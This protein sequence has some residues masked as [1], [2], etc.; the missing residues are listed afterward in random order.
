MTINKV[1]V[2][3]KK[4]GK[5]KAPAVDSSILM[6]DLLAS[7]TYPLT[8]TEMCAQTAIPLASGHR[9]ISVLLEQQMV[10]LDPG[11]KKSYCLGSKI[12]QIASTVYNRQSIIPFFYPIAEILKNELHKS[13]FLCMPVGSKVV[14]I[15]KVESSINQAINLFIGQTLAMHSSASGQAILS[16]YSQQT[17]QSY[18][19]IEQKQD[20]NI[21]L[22]F[23]QIEQSIARSKLLGYSV[24]HD[25]ADPQVSHIAAPI[26]NLR[27]EPV[28]AI[29]IAMTSEG[30]SPQLSRSYSKNLIQAARQLSSRII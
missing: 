1:T 17:Q 20:P 28:A 9:I 24:A 4:P 13:V 15:S 5:S 16:M 29:G 8:L 19:Q 11:R 30:L 3:Q 6:L 23:A 27:N 7:T 14:V 21:T 10:A 26:L 25:Q 2:S 18:M 22:Q 12:F